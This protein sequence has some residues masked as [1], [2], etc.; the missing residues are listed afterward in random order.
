MLS[1]IDFQC[2]INCFITLGKSDSKVVFDKESD[3]VICHIMLKLRQ[4]PSARKADVLCIR[5]DPPCINNSNI[6]GKGDGLT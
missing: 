1:I 6:S 3:K 2:H 5:F 4:L